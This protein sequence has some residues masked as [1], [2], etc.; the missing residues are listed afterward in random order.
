MRKTDVYDQSCT[1]YEFLGLVEHR[2]SRG[3]D[4]Y[5]T[6][7]RNAKNKKFYAFEDERVKQVSE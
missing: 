5:R 4:H 6:I 2:N 7:M 1:Q 3:G